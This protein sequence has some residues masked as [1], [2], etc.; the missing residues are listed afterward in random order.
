M[1]KKEFT[2]RNL[3][4][5]A[6]EPCRQGTQPAPVITQDSSAARP[7]RALPDRAHAWGVEGQTGP[8][9]GAQALGEVRGPGG[10]RAPTPSS[11]ATRATAGG[12]DF[13]AVSG[14]P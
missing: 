6:L 9:G 10:E 13:N 5:S 2:R 14:S 12:C 7:H 1:G 3:Q 8:A 4:T 11:G